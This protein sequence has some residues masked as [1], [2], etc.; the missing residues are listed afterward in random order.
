MM[1]EKKGNGKG[2]EKGGKSK[3]W[4]R[5]KRNSHGRIEPRSTW[6]AVI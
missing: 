6:E 5:V 4:E 2:G 3:L 1:K